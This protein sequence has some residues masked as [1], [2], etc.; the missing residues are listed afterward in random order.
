M[1]WLTLLVIAR[2]IGSFIL[3]AVAFSPL[4]GAAISLV[5]TFAFGAALRVRDMYG[6]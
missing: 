3:G 6:R 1:E 2:M 5:T 4:N